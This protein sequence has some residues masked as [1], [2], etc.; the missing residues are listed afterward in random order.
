[1]SAQYIVGL[2]LLTCS[3][4]VSGQ[5]MDA[6]R[7]PNRPFSND[8]NSPLASS[9]ADPFGERPRTPFERLRQELANAAPTFPADSEPSGPAGTVSVGELRNAPPKPELSVLQRADHSATA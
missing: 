3:F 9:P 4:C 8:P 5:I 2:L 7:N 6:S 1:M